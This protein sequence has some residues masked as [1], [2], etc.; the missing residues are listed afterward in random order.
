MNIIQPNMST[1]GKF[2]DL[3][4]VNKSK[5]GSRTRVSRVRPGWCQ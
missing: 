4:L 1:I 5:A 3:D 2:Y